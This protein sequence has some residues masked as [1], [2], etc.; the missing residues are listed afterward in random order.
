MTKCIFLK[1]F[2]L[3]ISFI[4]TKQNKKPNNNNK[5]KQKLKFV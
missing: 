3:F 2:T 5:I 4:K 1:V